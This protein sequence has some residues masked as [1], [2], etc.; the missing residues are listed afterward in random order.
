MGNIGYIPSEVLIVKL[1]ESGNVTKCE[2]ILKPKS[3]L[4]LEP[5]LHSAGNSYHEI[6]YNGEKW[7]VKENDISIISN[8]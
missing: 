2:K 6:L 3:V 4:I 1:N 8:I 7:F 5:P